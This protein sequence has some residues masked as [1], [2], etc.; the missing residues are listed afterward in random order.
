[1]GAGPSLTGSWD[2]E[3]GMFPQQ[4]SPFSSFS[5]TLE[6]GLCVAFLEVSS[7]SDFLF[8]G[9]L[10]QEFGLSASLGCVCFDGMMLFEPQTGSFLYAQGML[11]FDFSPFEIKLYS[12]MVGPSVSGGWNNGYVL[13]LY[14]EML[15]GIASAEVAIFLGADLSGITFTA[16]QTTSQT[17]SYAVWSLL[18][19]TYMTDPT[20]DPCLYSC[21][22]GFSGAEFT[23]K[24]CAFACVELTSITTFACTGF[25][26][27]EIELS[28]VNLFGT[29]LT[30][31]LDY[32]FE[33]QTASHT[34]I[35]S[36]ET[37][38][39]CVKVYNNILQDGAKLTG[40]EIYG[41]AFQVTFAGATFTSVSNLDTSQYVITLPEYG[42]IVEP[43]TEA[44]QEGHLYYPPEYWEVVSLVVEIP[45]AGC[46]S[47][48][49]VDTFFSTSTGLLFDWGRSKM[50]ASFSNGGFFSI[51]SGVVVD[52]TGFN[53]WTIGIS[54]TW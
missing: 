6:V 41:I 19:K 24:A 34:F 3:I 52:T 16:S 31:T 9:W 11:G 43:L 10:W 39:G 28:F 33:L 40:I 18:T 17:P 20:A 53:E 15:G 42:L 44:Q 2:V 46:G 26:S 23:F 12:A 5:S 36:L 22:V 37:D 1:M 32:L 45:P 50:K 25:D 8:D 38:F 48:F 13:D 29:S 35:P 21:G 14:G 30:I 54:V 4:T 47:T 51:S 49:S 27:Q 7:A